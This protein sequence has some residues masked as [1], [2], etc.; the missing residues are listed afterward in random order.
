MLSAFSHSGSLSNGSVFEYGFNVDKRNFI[1]LDAKSGYRYG[2]FV[3]NTFNF[4]I[5]TL[6][7]L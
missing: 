2:T 6:V 5:I 4:Q 7:G 3:N 1:G